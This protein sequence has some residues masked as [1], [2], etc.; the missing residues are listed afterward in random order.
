MVYVHIETLYLEQV[1]T[2]GVSSYFPYKFPEIVYFLAPLEHAEHVEVC[3]TVSN[4]VGS[5]S[6]NSGYQP[7]TLHCRVTLLL[8]S[9]K[10]SISLFSYS[11]VSRKLQREKKSLD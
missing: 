2:L 10:K 5:E 9:G 4:L 11:F 1:T 6:L 7:C 3:T 8:K